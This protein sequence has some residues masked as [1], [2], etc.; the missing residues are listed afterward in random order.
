MTLVRSNTY[1]SDMMNL[2]KYWLMMYVT[3]SKYN[4]PPTPIDPPHTT[5]TTPSHAPHGDIPCSSVLLQI[6]AYLVLFCN[7]PKV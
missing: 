5:H 1:C 4:D 3:F 6:L 2:T 7:D